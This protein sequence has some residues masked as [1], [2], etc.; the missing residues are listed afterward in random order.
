MATNAMC[1]AS[2][3]ECNVVQSETFAF[4]LFPLFGYVIT[5]TIVCKYFINEAFLMEDN[6]VTRLNDQSFS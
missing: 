6:F 5:D 1:E 3:L 2:T 4:P